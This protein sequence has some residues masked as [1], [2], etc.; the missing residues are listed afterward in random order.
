[1]GWRD[2]RNLPRARG[3]QPGAQE[4]E[5]LDRRRRELGGLQGSCRLRKQGGS[6]APHPAFVWWLPRP[7]SKQDLLFDKRC[8]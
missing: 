2:P 8:C 4:E 7:A 6:P 1:M 5:E 3:T